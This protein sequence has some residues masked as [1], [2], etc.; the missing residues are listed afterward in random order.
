[1]NNRYSVQLKV[2]L[3]NRKSIEAQI[4]QAVRFHYPEE[5]LALASITI[6]ISA[7]KKTSLNQDFDLVFDQIFTALYKLNILASDQR[8]FF[9]NN[10]SIYTLSF[11]ESEGPPVARIEIKN[12]PLSARY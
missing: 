6:K 3:Q 1:M 11:K 10:G 4:A 2:L 12:L 9:L 5:P 8:Q 7:D